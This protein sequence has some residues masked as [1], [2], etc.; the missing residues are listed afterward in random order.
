VSRP[1]FT[2]VIPTIGRDTL[3]RTLASIR[4][5]LPCNDAEVLIGV[6]THTDLSHEAWQMIR[7][8]SDFY[9]A[10]YYEL[11]A[12]R[13]DM[14]S[15]QIAYGMAQAQGLWLL[16]CGDDDIYVPGAFNV[17]S[18]AIAEQAGPEHPLMFKVELRANEARGNSSAILWSHRELKRFKVTGQSFVTPNDPARLGE[19]ENDWR[20]MQTTVANYGG[21]VDWREELTMR[22]Y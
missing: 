15:P 21:M 11:D 17:M 10:R 12:G 6:D 3:P 4:S 22:C 5:Q 8:Y 13:H 14:G 9:A 19:W 20:F 1:L 16:N 7:G 2:V 18:R